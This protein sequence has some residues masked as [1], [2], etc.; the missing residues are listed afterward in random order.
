MNSDWI[1]LVIIFMFIAALLWTASGNNGVHSD[2][3]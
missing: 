3:E 2:E 1:V